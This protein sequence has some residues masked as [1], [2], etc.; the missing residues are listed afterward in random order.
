MGEGKRRGTEG[1]GKAHLSLGSLGLAAHGSS[2]LLLREWGKEGLKE[3]GRGGADN[4][5]RKL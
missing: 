4:T 1:G 2:W 3:R 5:S